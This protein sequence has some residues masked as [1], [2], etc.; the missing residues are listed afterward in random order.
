MA[1]IPEGIDLAALLAPVAGEAPAGVDLRQDFS[2]QSTYYRLRDAR[3]EAR[4]AERTADS[5]AAAEGP[6]PLQWRTIRELGIKALAEKSK[7]LEIAAWLTEALVR[8]D[9]LVGLAAGAQLMSGLVQRYWESGLYP[10]A[11]EEGVATRVAPVTG[12][13]GEGGD[14]TLI[15]PLRKLTLF[16]RADGTALAYWQYEQAQEVQGIGDAARRQARIAAGVLPLEQL[17]QEARAAGPAHFK[18]LREACRAAIAAW[19]AL[20]E[21]LDAAAGADGPPTSR[22]RDLL[23]QIAAVIER[24]APA[25]AVAAEPGPAGEEAAVETGAAARPAAPA[26][27]REGMLA[28]LDRIAAFFRRTE[29]HSPLAYTLEEAARRGR[30]PWPDLLV[31][32]V[33]DLAARTAILNSLGIKPPPPEPKK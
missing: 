23:G 19:G 9:G 27:T 22:V 28:E 12:L 7:D 17:E 25:E 33:P 5:D 20:G 2:P 30:L 18:V 14:G 24:H 11:D 31:E 15:Q 16:R 13:N 32:L 21:A 6:P 1:R 8:S 26:E 3:S 4:A 10:T 29:P